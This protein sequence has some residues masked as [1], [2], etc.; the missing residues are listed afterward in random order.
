MILGNQQI[1]GLLRGP[2]AAK[3]IALL[4]PSGSGK[5]TITRTDQNSILKL[6][7]ETYSVSISAATR[8]RRENE[9]HG[10]DYFFLNQEDFQ[11]CLFLET[12]EYDGNN[13]LYGTLYSEAERIILHEKKAM[14]LDID[15]N[16]AMRLSDIFKI[17]LFTVFLK[18]PLETLRTRLLKRRI[19]TG[20]TE[21]Q[22][23]Q[24]IE[25]AKI[26]YKKVEDKIFIPN[27]ILD[28]PDS[29]APGEIV[30]EILLKTALLK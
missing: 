25:A 15:I 18:T 29:V 22:I 11:K 23:D 10:F 9:L 26:E 13:K 19:S 5:T 20:E 3:H 8:V 4:G 6:K 17:E 12:N 27:L 7:P 2:L 28:Y 14:L 16:G 21:I 30:N 1:K 24:R